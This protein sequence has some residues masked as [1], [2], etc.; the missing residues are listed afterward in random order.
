VADGWLVRSE[1]IWVQ[2]RRDDSPIRSLTVLGGAARLA[3]NRRASHGAKNLWLLIYG[4]VGRCRER[5]RD[6]RRA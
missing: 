6:E 4:T 5:R 1:V 2:T 3:G